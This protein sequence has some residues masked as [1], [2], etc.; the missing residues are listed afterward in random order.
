MVFLLMIL[1]IFLK[2]LRN[3]MIMFVSALVIFSLC[4][5]RCQVKEI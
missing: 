2:L 4:A 3:R 1:S 5:D